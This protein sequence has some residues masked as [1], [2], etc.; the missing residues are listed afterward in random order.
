[1]GLLFLV[2]D[3]PLISI[4]R[5]SEGVYLAILATLISLI[6]LLCQPMIFILA[7]MSECAAHVDKLHKNDFGDI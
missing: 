1:M 2:M 3:F 6:M 5:G 7:S 4:L